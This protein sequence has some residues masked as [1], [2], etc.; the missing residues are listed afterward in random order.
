MRWRTVLTPEFLSI[1]SKGWTCPLVFLYVFPAA[2]WRSREDQSAPLEGRAARAVVRRRKRIG[3][4]M[5]GSG[6][7]F[8]V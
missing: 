1:V 4:R 5:V 6:G 3:R 7:V 8:G 2:S